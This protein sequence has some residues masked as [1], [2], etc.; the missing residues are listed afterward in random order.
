M[1]ISIKDLQINGEIRDKELRVIGADGEQ[2]GVM[3]LDEA[4]KLA[5]G[6]DLDLVK[7]VPKANPPVA[8]VMD[9]NKHRY[10]QA[11]KEKE[12]KKNQKVI[13]VKEIRLSVNIDKHDFDTKLQ[14]AIKFL[15]QGNRVKVTIRFRGRQMAHANFG[16]DAMSRFAEGVAEYGNVEKQPKLEGRSM[17]MFIAAKPT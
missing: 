5:I 12:A 1:T 7:I 16:Y 4:Q 13:E 10:E 11:K 15:K 6:Q 8:K 17:I 2:L 9:Y 3:T 14:N